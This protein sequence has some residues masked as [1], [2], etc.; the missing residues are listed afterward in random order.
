[1]YMASQG[2]SYA[3]HTFPHRA[4]ESGSAHHVHHKN[5]R[6]TGPESI[7]ATEKSGSRGL[8]TGEPV[9]AVVEES[10]GVEAGSLAGCVERAV[11]WRV[12]EGWRYW[13]V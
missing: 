2:K 13:G 7:V 3:W 11:G 12:L 4:G 10:A 8:S 1:M 6:D 5:Q 9:A